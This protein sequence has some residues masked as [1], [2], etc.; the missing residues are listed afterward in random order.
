MSSG[1]AARTRLM[2][3]TW[4]SATAQRCD[5]GFRALYSTVLHC[6]TLYCTVLY[7]AVPVL[8][9]EAD[10]GEG[11]VDPHGG[12]V[13]LPLERLEHLPCEPLAQRVAPLLHAGGL[14]QPA[15]HRRVPGGV[16]H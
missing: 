7:R 14:V 13:D 5:I 15:E 3:A 1:L 6:T 4:T 8:H 16:E 2:D 11:V 9:L 12:G 10:D